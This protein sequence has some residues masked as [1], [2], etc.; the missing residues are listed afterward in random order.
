MIYKSHKKK[1]EDLTPRGQYKRNILE[2]ECVCC[3]IPI[4]PGG[5]RYKIQF[6]CS[7]KCAEIYSRM[8]Y[9]LGIPILRKIKSRQEVHRY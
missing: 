1:W 7:K 8:R 5:K 9:Q 4:M 2:R 3:G 6:Y